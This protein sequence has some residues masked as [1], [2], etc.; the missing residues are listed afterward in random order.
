MSLNRPSRR[1]VAVPISAVVFGLMATQLVHAFPPNADVPLDNPLFSVDAGSPVVGGPI[2][3]SDLLDKPGPFV[4]IPA[5]GLGVIAM[6]SDLDGVTTS[7]DVLGPMDEF[8]ILFTVSRSSTGSAAPDAVLTGLGKPF[9][10]TDQAMRSQATGDVYMTTQAFTVSGA[11]GGP[12]SANNVLVLNQGD[13][14]GVDM[15]L[16]P[17]TSPLTM[18]PP[19]VIDSVDA[20]DFPPAVTGLPFGGSVP[21]GGITD[22]STVFFTLQEGSAALQEL[23]STV[24]S[25][26]NIYLDENPFQPGGEDIFLRAVQLGLNP[27]GANADDI[28]G[29]KLF[30]PDANGIPIQEGSGPRGV[31]GTIGVLFSLTPTSGSLG[32][33]M[34]PADIFISTGGGTFTL[35][36][37][38]AEL[39]LDPMDD[40]T[41]LSLILTDDAMGLIEDSAIKLN[42]PGDTDGDLMIS[43][44]ECSA[45]ASCYSGDGVSYDFDGVATFDV[46]VGPGSAFSPGTITIEVGDTVHWTW[47]DGPH[48][49]VSGSPGVP[50]GAFSSGPPTA[51]VGSTFM[52]AFDE[53]FLNAYPKSTFDYYSD[54]DAGMTGTVNVS[55]DACA[56]FDLDLDGDVDCIDWQQFRAI[57]NDLNGADCI[58]LTIPEFAAALVCNPIDPAHICMADVNADGAADGLDMHGY[59]QYLLTGP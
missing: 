46:S 19:M 48:N 58:P 24:P 1:T 9:N 7:I 29:M 52:V 33:G 34:S 20:I 22:F 35:F 38:A 57:Y 45:F 3:E 44:T 41:S 23:P 28:D 26:A 47:A 37:S 31:P 18:V 40:I 14:G 12:F 4:A 55:P 59:I 17:N 10:V 42:V 5:V 8:V 36:A 16:E 49:V 43:H 11:T 27:L 51:V 53:F 56:T 6:P 25:G 50:D 39:G 13:V 54:P 2:T 15:D 30:F 21:R 32:P